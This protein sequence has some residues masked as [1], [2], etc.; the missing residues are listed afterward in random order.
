MKKM[1][2]NA[3]LDSFCGESQAHIK[4]LIYAEKAEED[5]KP[6]LARLF[7]AISHA[8]YVHAKN[9]FKAL[10]KL[11]GT[12]ENVAA[13]ESGEDFEIEEMYP[14]YNAIANLQKEDAAL[15]SIHYAIE[16]EKIHRD[17]YR[18]AEDLVKAGKDVEDGKIYVCPVCGYTH[19]GDGDLPEKCPVCGVPKGKFK[20]F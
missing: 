11:N 5:G 4:Y 18:K 10:G 12:A 1:T 7:R 17:Y 9:H 13:A 15:R 14:S 6:N 2:E 8:E 19:S 20:S 16:A 3:L